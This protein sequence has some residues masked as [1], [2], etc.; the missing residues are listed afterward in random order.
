M[1][2]SKKLVILSL[3]LTNIFLNG[4]A[5]GQEKAAR[6]MN[7][8][9]GEEMMKICIREGATNVVNKLNERDWDILGERVASG[10][11]Y[12]VEASACLIQ[13]QNFFIFEERDPDKRLGDY[14][15]AVL[16]DAWR[17][18]LLKKPE[19]ILELRDKISLGW[20]CSYPYEAVLDETHTVEWADDYLEQGL[21]ALA[22]VDDEFL[23]MEKE[24]CETYLKHYHKT[25][26]ELITNR[27]KRG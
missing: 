3:V 18:V 13:G 17:E 19:T 12:W 15:T 20:T 14:V 8:P 1:K 22:K 27:N 9:D 25:V 4:F 26:R 10:D 11:R 2:T 21:S 23:Q 7:V 6:L 16:S 5:Y 24:V